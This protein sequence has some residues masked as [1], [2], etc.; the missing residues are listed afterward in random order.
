MKKIKV[1][2]KESFFLSDVLEMVEARQKARK[3]KKKK[4][5]V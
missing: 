1:D 2:N 4:K 5:E 3:K